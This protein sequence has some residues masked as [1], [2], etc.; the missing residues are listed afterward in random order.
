MASQWVGQWQGQWDGKLIGPIDPNFLTGTSTLYLSAQGSAYG[1]GLLAGDALFSLSALGNIENGVS[2]VDAYGS[3]G[4]Q[5]GASATLFG[6]IQATGTAG[7]Q[8][9]ASATLIGVLLA[10]G[11]AQIVISS[12]GEAYLA[13]NAA[14]SATVSLSSTGTTTALGALLGSGQV[15]IDGN[16]V[17]RGIG[18]LSGASAVSILPNGSIFS[19]L[20]TSGSTDITLGITGGISGAL[21]TSGQAAIDIDASAMLVGIG[22]IAGQAW[23]ALNTRY[24]DLNKY[25]R[26]YA[27]H[28][29]ET[30]YALDVVEQIVSIA[31]RHN[32]SAIDSVDVVRMQTGDKALFILPSRTVTVEKPQ[33]QAKQAT[34]K[35]IKE[36][37]VAYALTGNAPVYASAEQ[38]HAF[39]NQSSEAIVSSYEQEMFFITKTPSRS[40]HTPKE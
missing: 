9:G 21:W 40:A 13:T 14:G 17:L 35:P 34:P 11:A 5:L 26:A 39:A 38:L 27:R 19:P 1:A 30:V 36:T 25:Q 12:T 8:F 18:S 22:S 10:T 20:W 4:I 6:T 15:S 33:R 32:L 28:V 29:L 24:F 23:F 16:A 37:R 2:V 31:E 7:V 3:S